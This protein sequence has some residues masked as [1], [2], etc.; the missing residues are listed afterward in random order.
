M[1]NLT[2]YEWVTKQL[3]IRWISLK[4]ESLL[5]FF[6]SRKKKHFELDL[7]VHKVL[8]RK[9]VWI[10]TYSIKIKIIWMHTISWINQI[11]PNIIMLMLKAFSWLDFYGRFDVSILFSEIYFEEST[12]CSWETDLGRWRFSPGQVRLQTD[13][14]QFYI[15]VDN[16][17]GFLLVII[18][19]AYRKISYVCFLISWNNIHWH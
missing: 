14:N 6:P 7:H 3:K 8:I 19:V 15:K 13:R 5:I 10:C 11:G 1:E 16:P 12:S 17:R 2:I 4:P 9:C 18:I